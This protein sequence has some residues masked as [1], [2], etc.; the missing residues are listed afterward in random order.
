MAGPPTTVVEE[1]TGA[2]DVFLAALSFFLFPLSA[3][4]GDSGKG[5]TGK[6][7]GVGSEY[8]DEGIDPNWALDEDDADSSDI[9]SGRK[10]RT[11]SNSQNLEIS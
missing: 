2:A 5:T 3:V 10:I 4:R 8:S 9:F 7:G 6:A 11:F 1:G